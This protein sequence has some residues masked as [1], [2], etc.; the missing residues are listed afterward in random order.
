MAKSLVSLKKEATELGLTFEDDVKATELEKQIDAY[1][2]SQETSGAE[3][4]AT[5]TK[6]EA[7]QA[8]KREKQQEVN[9]K[10]A[11]HIG[12]LA[13]EAEEKAR[14]TRV[15]KVFDNDNRVNNQ[16]TVAVAN[17]SNQYFDLGTVYIPLN[18]PVEVM[19]GHIDALKDVMIPQHTKGVDG[20]TKTSV[21]NRYMISYEDL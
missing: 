9:M 16:T 21:R 10:N 3:L 14:K 13:R 19:Q 18:E 7:A 2:E 4:E 20:L 15:I 5:I 17:C 1:Y 11:R 8:E 6:V 12:A